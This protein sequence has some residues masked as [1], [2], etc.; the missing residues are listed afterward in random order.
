MNQTSLSPDDLKKNIKQWANELGFQDTRFSD[1]DLDSCSNHY[2][3]WI[4]NKFHGSMSYMERNTDK[5]F[6]PDLLVPNTISIISVRINYLPKERGHPIDL[7]DISNQAYISR[8]AL[9]R[10]YHKVIRKKLQKLA[11]IIQQDIGDFGYRAFTDSAPILEKP[12]ASKAGIGWVGKHSNILNK[13]NGSWFFLG[14]IYL[15]IQLPS[16]EAI[17]DHCGT[18]SSCI[19]V[20]PTQ[21]IVEPYVVDA[22]KCISYLTIE[23]KDS[24]P[25][26]YRK[27]IGNRIYGCDDCQLF[28]PW[29]KFA[30]YSQEA[31]FDIRHSLDNISLL[32]CFN[33]REDEFLSK[34]EGSPIRRIGYQSW[35]RNCAVALGNAT[36]SPDIEQ[37]LKA[38]D[39]GDNELLQE[40]IDWALKEIR[41]EP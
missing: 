9:G 29:N 14:E 8:Y 15:D 30:Q 16:D 6:Q 10:D 1:C 34:M 23:N 4:Q 20:C 32:E 17:N 3:Q 35:I 39:V 12:I 13:E 2:Q 31:D 28:C 18:C 5:R 25:I 37:A 24:I 27:A 36:Y 11:N 33:W 26:E 22:R 21:A 19:D 41:N 38:K 40:H 7:L